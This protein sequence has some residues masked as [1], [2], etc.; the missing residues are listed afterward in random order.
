MKLYYPHAFPGLALFKNPYSFLVILHRI[1]QSLESRSSSLVPCIVMWSLHVVF[2]HI[3]P[4][5]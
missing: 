5:C 1:P 2:L 3:C 4:V